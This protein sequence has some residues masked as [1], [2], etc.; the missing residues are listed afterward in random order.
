[1]TTNNA[2][3][4]KKS[5]KAL[6]P[7]INDYNC[8]INKITLEQSYNIKNKVPVEKKSKFDMS[9]FMHDDSDD[10]I[11]VKKQPIKPEAKKPEL[12]PNENF[13]T[14]KHI[15]Y[16]GFYEYNKIGS[17]KLCILT[18]FT[19]VHKLDIKKN[20]L[21]LTID[22]SD[23]NEH[24]L[25]LKNLLVDITNKI[26]NEITKQYPTVNISYPYKPAESLVEI[27]MISLK[28]QK[29]DLQKLINTPIHIHRS[30]KNGG[31][32]VM[33]ENYAC[34]D[35]LVKIKKEFPK[36]IQVPTGEIFFTARSSL[37]FCAKIGEYENTKTC[38]I[39][40]YAKE[41]E[42]KYNASYVT[43]IFNKDL[44]VITHTPNKQVDSLEL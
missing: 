21:I 34:N 43:S 35:M 26:G 6:Y 24:N 8:D 16:D 4:Q 11:P 13:T 25:T 33:F 2:E 39:K 19:K 9:D 7:L 23:A 42:L 44:T 30:K 18:H 5:I 27:S 31:N 17:K 40:I 1:M 15:G 32:V 3:T 38:S 12:N 14:I 41:M 37:I 29:T 28:K 36:I 22:I 10:D 20:E